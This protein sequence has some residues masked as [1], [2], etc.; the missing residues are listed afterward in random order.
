ME[1]VGRA[2]ICQ[3]YDLE[4]CLGS[5]PLKWP[6]GV[7]FIATNHLVAV[8]EDFCWWSHRTVRYATRHCPVR[9]PRHPTVRVLMVLTVGALTSWG[10]GQSS[11]APD[12]YCSLS[13]VPSGAALTLHELSTHCSRCRWT[14]DLIVALA[15]RCSGGTP[16]S[17]VNY[18]GARSRK[19]E[20]E[21]FEVNLPWCARPGCS[22]ISFCSF[23][24]NP[25]LFFLL[26][27][28]EPLAPVEHII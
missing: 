9:Q 13:S 5:H 2:C 22:S 15:S 20:G 11:A 17:P 7:V 23:L 21:E 24:L 8:G 1:V 6:V 28:V 16:D 14:L 12:R 4:C 25:N 3:L 26:V 27:C 10:T 18:S 19:P